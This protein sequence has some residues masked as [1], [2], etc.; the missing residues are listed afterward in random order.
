M[1]LNDVLLKAI[2]KFVPLKIFVEPKFPCWVAGDLKSLIYKKNKAY[3]IIYKQSKQL[4]DY[5]LFS[6]L[7]AKCKFRFKFYFK[8]HIKETE[9]YNF[10]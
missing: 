7:R 1:V 3:L 9:T 10:T 5:L 6:E 4:S 8:S 2:G